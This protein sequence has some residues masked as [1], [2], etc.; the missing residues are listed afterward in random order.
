MEVR[1]F[2]LRLGKFKDDTRKGSII[3]KKNIDHF[4]DEGT[5]SYMRMRWDYFD[6][7][8]LNASNILKSCHM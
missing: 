1:R 6:L 8:F 4:P 5:L 2:T 3:K 7:I